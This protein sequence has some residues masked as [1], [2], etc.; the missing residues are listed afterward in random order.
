MEMPNC[1]CAWKAVVPVQD[2]WISLVHPIPHPLIHGLLF[3]GEEMI[4]FS[5]RISVKVKHQMFG[6]SGGY[7]YLFLY[8]EKKEKK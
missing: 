2:T 8:K 7:S 4:V 3:S 5:E 1:L 6:Q